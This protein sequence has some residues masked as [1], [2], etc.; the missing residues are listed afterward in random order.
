MYIQCLTT[1]DNGRAVPELRSDMIQC[2]VCRPTLDGS[3]EH[4]VLQ[5]SSDEA[6]YPDVW[7]VVTG[8]I[9][10]GESAVDTVRRELLEETGLIPLSLHVAPTTATFYSMRTDTVHIIPV[11]AAIV[12]RDARVRLS[13]EHQAGEWLAA[14]DAAS[15]LLIPSHRESLRI[16]REH[17]LGNPVLADLLTIPVAIPPVTP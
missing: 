12:A 7:Q 16:V 17:I 6:V 5:R 11:F 15:R 2:H 3:Y 10:A 14:D 1:H 13:S 9:D 4:L 8:T